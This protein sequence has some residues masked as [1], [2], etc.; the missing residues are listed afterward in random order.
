[1]DEHPFGLYRLVD[2]NPWC[3]AFERGEIVIVHDVTSE[4]AVVLHYYAG[5][6]HIPWECLEKIDLEEEIS[7]RRKME[8]NI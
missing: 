5:I 2:D 8:N 1:M 3:F 6:E 7:K 4:Y